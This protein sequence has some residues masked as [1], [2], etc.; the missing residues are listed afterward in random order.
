M[1]NEYK[2]YYFS[3]P[4]DGKKVDNNVKFENYFNFKQSIRSIR[5][6]QVN[7]IVIGD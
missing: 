6:H 2:L 4:K 3:A 1:N 7:V 5:P